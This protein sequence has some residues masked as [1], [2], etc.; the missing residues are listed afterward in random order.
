MREEEC[1]ST[2]RKIP[3]FL[4][5]SPDVRKIPNKPVLPHKR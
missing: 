1:C 5:R 2:S 3:W 4:S